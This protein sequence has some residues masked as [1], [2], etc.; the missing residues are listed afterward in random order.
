MKQFNNKNDITANTM[1][2]DVKPEK[3]FEHSSDSKKKKIWPG[4]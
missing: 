3:Y 4:Y 1:P 2:A